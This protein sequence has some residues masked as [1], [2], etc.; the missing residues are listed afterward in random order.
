[1]SNSSICPIDRILS[2][3]TTPGQSGPG[4]NGNEVVPHIPRSF[5]I[6]RTSPSDYL[7]SYQWH[8]LW[9]GGLTPLER[10]SRCILQPQPIGPKKVLFYEAFYFFLLNKKMSSY[11][12][13][14]KKV[15]WLLRCV[16]RFTIRITW[17]IREKVKSNCSLGLKKD[18]QNSSLFQLIF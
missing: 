14:K 10:C 12:W 8:S 3:A 16:V 15:E 4:S 2:G 6:T 17:L 11:F 5:S 9:G 18:K 13:L 7:M 1:M